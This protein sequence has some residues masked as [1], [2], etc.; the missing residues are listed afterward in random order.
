V[1]GTQK[2]NIETGP[3]GPGN[4][5]DN[6]YLNNIAS[7]SPSNYLNQLQASNGFYAGYVNSSW[8][9]LVDRTDGACPM[10]NPT[11]AEVLQWAANKW[12]INPLLMYAEA[13]NESHWDQTAIGDHGGSSGLFQVADRNTSYEPKHTFPGFAGAGSMLA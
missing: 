2:S 10:A 12:G 7:T 1:A 5:A 11:S 9:A 13:T 6:N 3:T 8:R 4:A